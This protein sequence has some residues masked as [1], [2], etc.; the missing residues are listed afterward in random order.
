VIKMSDGLENSYTKRIR[1]CDEC[2]LHVDPDPR[3]SFCRH[4]RG[5]GDNYLIGGKGN[6]PLEAGAFILRIQKY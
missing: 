4:P 6:C 3:P 1:S 2:L 5:N